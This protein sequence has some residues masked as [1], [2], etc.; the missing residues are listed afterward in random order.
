MKKGLDG[1]Q[2]RLAKYERKSS[3]TKIAKAAEKLFSDIAETTRE[4]LRTG[5]GVKVSDLFGDPR[6][7]RE[8]HWFENDGLRSETRPMIETLL[9][10]R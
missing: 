5:F 4:V 2:E 3:T 8:D 10:L 7:L 6:L 9:T 1:D